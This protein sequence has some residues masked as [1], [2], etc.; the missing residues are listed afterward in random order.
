MGERVL[1]ELLEESYRQEFSQYDNSPVF[2]TSSKHHRTMSRIFRIYEK[3]VCRL[4]KTQRNQMLAPQPIRRVSF[5]AILITVIVVF[6]AVLAGCT[7]AYFV[8]QNFRGRITNESTNILP[9]NTENCPTTIEEIYNISDIPLGFEKVSDNSNPYQRTVEYQDDSTKRM[10][11]FSQ[12]TKLEFDTINLNTEK[13]D[14]IEI[15][16]NGYKGIYLG[17]ESKNDSYGGVLWDN[18]EYVFKIFANLPKNQIIDL[19]NSVAISQ[20]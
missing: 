15:E 13:N 4:Y 16:V 10:I 8:S 7:V 6:L 12:Y 14:I 17:Q 20:K 5:K 9:I 19:A 1:V 18:G 2:K 3:N 11:C